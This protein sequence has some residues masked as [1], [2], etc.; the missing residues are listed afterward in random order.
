M[1]SDFEKIERDVNTM[2]QTITMTSDPIGATHEDLELKM[3]SDQIGAT[4]TT[5]TLI[6]ALK[7]TSDLDV[8]AHETAYE[9]NRAPRETRT[10]T[11]TPSQFM[12]KYHLYAVIHGETF[13]RNGINRQGNPPPLVKLTWRN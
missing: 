5:T 12:K 10:T 11:A 13:G 9:M 8:T 4:Q 2:T 6:G 3:T 1:T 7:M